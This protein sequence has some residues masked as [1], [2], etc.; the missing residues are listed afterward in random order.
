[1]D[2]TLTIND[3]IYH[4]ELD[5]PR[6]KLLYLLRE[7]LQLTGTKDGCASGHCGTCVV[8]INGKPIRACLQKA[9]KLE[10]AEI[11][12]IEGISPQK[13]GDELHPIQQA[14]VDTTGVQCGFCTPGIIMKLYGLFEENLKASNEEIVDALEGHLCRC[15]G[16]TP[17]F[18]AA[19]RAQEF[20]ASEVERLL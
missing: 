19:I 5:D 12:T 16:Y 14:M 2:I 20:M 15:T 4:L 17:I 3:I 9:Q 8:L 11:L 18:E 10:G 7:R 13:L 1:M 6:E